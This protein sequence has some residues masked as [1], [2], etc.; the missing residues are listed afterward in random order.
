LLLAIAVGAAVVLA[1]ALGHSGSESRDASAPELGQSAGH[2]QLTCDQLEM[3]A[4]TPPILPE[5][6]VPAIPSVLESKADR[7]RLVIPYDGPL[8][9]FA[10]VEHSGPSVW[11]GLLRGL[12]DAVARDRDEPVSVVTLGAPDC[13]Q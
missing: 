1:S 12:R 4:E 11:T 10:R 3:L 5:R 2:A 6:S 8:P 13:N 7:Q 9:D